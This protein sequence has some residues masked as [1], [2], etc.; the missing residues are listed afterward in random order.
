M[1][2]LVQFNVRIVR[3]GLGAKEGWLYILAGE[4][5]MTRVKNSSLMQQ[6]LV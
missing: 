1:S 3:D 2:K 6:Q 4:R 5:K